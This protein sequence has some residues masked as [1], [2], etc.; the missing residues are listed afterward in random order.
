MKMPLDLLRKTMKMD[1]KKVVLSLLLFVLESPL[2]AASAAW[3]NEPAGFTTLT[4]FAFDNFTSG[5]WN[6][7]G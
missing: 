1:H 5:G 7:A 2:Y 3:P 4:D 6:T